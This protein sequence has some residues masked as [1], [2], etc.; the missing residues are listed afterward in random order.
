M[1]NKYVLPTLIVT[2]VIIA[3]IMSDEDLLKQHFFTK[4][5]E[6]AFISQVPETAKHSEITEKQ[7]QSQET[8]TTADK[9]ANNNMASETKLFPPERRQL[10]RGNYRK[11]NG[12]YVSRK[13]QLK[14]RI[15]G[16]RN[17]SEEKRHEILQN[18]QRNM[19]IQYDSEQE[20]H[21]TTNPI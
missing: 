10:A 15:K 16:F 2:S 3:I 12:I 11:I 4:T 14:E 8:T 6:I 1:S 19:I 21:N 13:Q 7:K 5:E 9:I 17:L 18:R 20:A